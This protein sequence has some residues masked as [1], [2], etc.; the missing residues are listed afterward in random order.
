DHTTADDARRYRDSSEVEKWIGRDPLIRT[1]KY[2]EKRGAWND[3]KQSDL[4]DR[5]KALV[6]EVVKN[7]EGIEKP[8][9]DDIFDY[10][11]AELPAE[12]IRQRETLK[13]HGL[14]QFPEQETLSGRAQYS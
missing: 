12:M 4:D 6:S 3:Q 13:T 10:T 7:A 14:G 8:S 9:I 2:L 5:A 1:R 11:Y